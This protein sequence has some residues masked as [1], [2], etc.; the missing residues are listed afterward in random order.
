[1][2]AEGKLAQLTEELVSKVKQ[3][4]GEKCSWGEIAG[5]IGYPG[6]NP[7]DNLRNRIKS[8]DRRNTSV[9]VAT[10]TEDTDTAV[11][12]QILEAFNRAAEENEISDDVVWDIATKYQK[13][14]QKPRPPRN[15]LTLNM[16]NQPIGIV[17]L[18][19]IHGGDVGC[20]YENM[21]RDAEIIRDT[22]G[23]WGV[24]GGDATNNFIHKKLIHATLEDHSLRFQWDIFTAYMRIVH[25]SLL[26][27]VSGN[28]D[29]WSL[30]MS[31]QDRLADIVRGMK[32]LYHED[33]YILDLTVGNIPYKVIVRHKY[34]GKS[35]FHVTHPHIRYF[36]ERK[37]YDVL[38]MGH[39]HEAGALMFHHDDGYSWAGNAGSYKIQD[40]Y[41]TGLGFNVASKPYMPGFI[42]HPHTKRIDFV[43]NPSAMAQILNSIRG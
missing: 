11:S 42:L 28:H 16:G 38:M 20:D 6:A 14:Y 12:N 30:T 1:M 7:G 15:I 18:F 2:E 22:P 13:E 35:G 39:T 23:M 9:P 5:V 21:R 4:R 10:A 34:K 36:R 26:C 41:A 31:G 25:G 43:E 19:D 37:R 17:G 24:F 33:E 29:A 3:M 8:Y 32:R 40:S 27:A